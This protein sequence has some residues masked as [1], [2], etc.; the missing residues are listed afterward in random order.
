MVTRSRLDR[1]IQILPDCHTNN[2][3]PADSSGRERSTQKGKPL[4]AARVVIDACRDLSWKDDWYPI[5]RIS[6][7]LRKEIMEKW[8]T[9]LSGSCRGWGRRFLQR[10][11]GI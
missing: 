7:E 8:K 9:V 1:A 11:K 4:T 10:I 5:S 3:H 6:P 2:V